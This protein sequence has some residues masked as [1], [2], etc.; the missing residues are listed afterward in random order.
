MK[1]KGIESLMEAIA[2][3]LDRKKILDN[4]SGDINIRKVGNDIIWDYKIKSNITP[5][6]KKISGKGKAA[7]EKNLNNI[8]KTE[9]IGIMPDVLCLVSHT[10]TSA[11]YLQI[12]G[13][14]VEDIKKGVIKFE[15]VEVT[16][17]KYLIS[18]CVETGLAL[19]D[20][21]IVYPIT[22][23]GMSSVGKFTDA[24]VSFKK[25]EPIP[26]GSALILYEKLQ[27]M[28]RVDMM[29]ENTGKNIK[30]IHAIC[31]GSF[32]VM[33]N[34]D[35]IKGIF[36]LIVDNGMSYDDKKVIWD[37]TNGITEA[38]VPLGRIL[39]SG[40]YVGSYQ[41]VIK[42][43]CSELPGTANKVELMAKLSEGY[44]SIE[45]RSLKKDTEFSSLVDGFVDKIIETEERIN[46]SSFIVTK[47]DIR[48]LVK[49]I[50]KKRCNEEIFTLQDKTSDI[51]SFV[52]KTYRE[53]K[54]KQAR[55][56]S[57][58]YKDILFREVS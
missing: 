3:N 48:N 5:N 58:Y 23:I 36:D 12:E 21:E 19:Y 31:S 56:L 6:A 53:L 17:D 54:W 8:F 20:N 2:S 18:K 1:G 25:I 35:F 26:L 46:N 13:L 49:I 47:E 45:E 22:E 10:A 16:G 42:I 50:G 51:T 11:K 14:D 7:L 40:A 38:V 32:S 57:L 30:P 41:P 55:E 43:R 29:Y 33:S 27:M 52:Y 15:E 37:I 9:S 39:L 44:V 4:S 34:V 28:R 24:I